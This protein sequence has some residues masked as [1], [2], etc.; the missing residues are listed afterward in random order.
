MRSAIW[1]ALLRQLKPAGCLSQLP[2]QRPDRHPRMRSGREQLHIIPT[3]ADPEELLF[4][5]KGQALCRARLL[6]ARESVEPEQRLFPLREIA[7]RKLTDDNAVNR[8]LRLREMLSEARKTAP[9]MFHP[10]GSVSQDHW[11]PAGVAERFSAVALHHPFRRG[12]APPRARSRLPIPFA[13]E[14]FFRRCQRA[15]RP[16]PAVRPEY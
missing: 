2:V 13:P 9:E 15:S 1:T 14:Q 6:N 4:F 5:E 3:N 12:V 7:G 8:D 16:Q 11:W 10:Y